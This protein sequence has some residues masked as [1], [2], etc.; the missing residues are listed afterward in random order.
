MKII[1]PT[2][3]LTFANGMCD[4][5]EVE[6]NKLADKKFTLCFGD[7]TVGMQRFFVARTATTEINRL[8][9]VPRQLAITA[10]DN[11]VIDSLRY[12]IEQLQ[13]LNDTNPPVTLLTLRQI[14]V[15]V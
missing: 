15:I 1:T 5:Y 10:K 11:V 12:K 8:I 9:Q 2:E 6:N 14:G 13:Q 3:F 7:R 4:I